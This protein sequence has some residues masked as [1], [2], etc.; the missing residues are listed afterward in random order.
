MR[1][2]RIA[3]NGLATLLYRSGLYR[4]PSRADGVTILRYHSVVSD[5]AEARRYVSPDVVVSAADFAKQMVFVKEH[6]ECV[7]LLDALHRV[8]DETAFDGRSKPLAAVTFDDG[9]ADNYTDA[10]PVLNQLGLP[11][12]IFLVSE[13][14][15]KRRAFWNVRLRHLF[16]L[17]LDAGTTVTTL[18]DGSTCDIADD[19]ARETLLRRVTQWLNGVCRSLKPGS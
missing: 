17:A 6:F 15:A 18:P 5:P 7:D 11:A 10:W 1:L 3:R 19:R 13:V 9:Y 8:R 4:L 16:F 2:K 14:Y 12:T